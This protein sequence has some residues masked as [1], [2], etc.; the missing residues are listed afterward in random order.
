MGGWVG[1]LGEGKQ[2]GLEGHVLDKRL[3]SQ[4]GLQ[5]FSCPPLHA[6]APA[7]GCAVPAVGIPRLDSHSGIFLPIP[8]LNSHSGIFLPIPLPHS[9]PPSHLLTPLPFPSIGLRNPP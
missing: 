7:P 3:L 6:H 2:W 9:F 8:R 5:L 1:G 4:T